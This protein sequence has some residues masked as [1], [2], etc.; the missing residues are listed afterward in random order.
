L[1]TPVKKAARI[2]RSLVNSLSARLA[3]TI[4]H[5][6]TS[7]KVAA[8]T[9]DDGPDPV[10]T[11]VLLDI[12]K[13]HNAHATFFMIGRAAE[14]HPDLVK[15]VA[16]A[17]NAIGIH[18]WDHPSFPSITSRERRRQ[19]LACSRAV[20]PYGCRLFR[21]PYAHQTLMSRLDALL[22]RHEVIAYN[23]HALDW[24]RRDAAWMAGE[25]ERKTFQ[26]SII[27]LHDS[28]WS[29]LVDGAQDRFPMLSALDMF[30]TEVKGQLRFVTV[31]ELLKLGRAQRRNW[32]V[33]NHDDW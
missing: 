24:E 25:L 16:E 29:V 15:K 31:P 1:L 20:A 11:P 6:S 7:D 26:G 2:T 10:F 23:V 3:G 32:Y 18:S 22:L 8:L 19:I 5:V 27:L 13:K 9:F 17:G 30:L 4:T 33:R 21:P 28:L 14:R 12:L